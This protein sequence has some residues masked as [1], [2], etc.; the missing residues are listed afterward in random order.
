MSEIL[1]AF[2][3]AVLLAVVRLDDGAYGRAILKEVEDRLHR[4]VAPGAIHAT[5]ER[6]LTKRLVA[7]YLGSGTA[8]RAGRER[9][10]YRLEPM[11]LQALDDARVAMHQLWRGLRWP[12]KV[13]GAT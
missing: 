3:Q 4:E 6:L 13:K 9:R 1:G 5:L 11:G 2:E 12:P 10:Y 8:N 7:S